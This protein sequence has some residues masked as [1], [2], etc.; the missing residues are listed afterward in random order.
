MENLF[1]KEQLDEL[2]KISKLSEEEQKNILP[3]FLRKLNPEQ[4]NSLKQSQS[5]QCP[6]CLIIEGKIK[7]KKIY[8]DKDLIAVLEINPIN[9]GHTLVF[10][11]QHVKIISQLKDVGP[12][13]NLVNKISVSLFD[14]L[15]AQGSNILVS[16]GE[17]A[18]QTVPHVVVNVIPRFDKDNLDFVFERKKMSE[19]ELNKILNIIKEKFN[20]YLYKKNFEEKP[21]QAEVVKSNKTERLP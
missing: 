8:E 4:L 3:N 13:F 1:T 9:K 17:L 14:S 15:K 16:N 2:T 6:F 19:E 21:K 20:Q 5:P 18:G 10:P 12:L 11:K 7:S